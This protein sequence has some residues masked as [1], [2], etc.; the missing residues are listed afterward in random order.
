MSDQDALFDVPAPLAAL[1]E[2]VARNVAAGGAIQ[3]Q[4]AGSEHRATFLAG[5]L[6]GWAL[7]DA[8]PTPAQREELLALARASVA[9]ASALVRRA[10]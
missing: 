6:S 10:P 5:L 1:R 3:E 9:R 4:P 7:G 2:T 8:K